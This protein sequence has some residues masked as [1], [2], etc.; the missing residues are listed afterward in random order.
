MSNDIQMG[1]INEAGAQSNLV[2][3]ANSDGVQ[4]LGAGS[5]SGVA[6]FGDPKESGPGIIGTGQGPGAPGVKGI[7]FEGIDS[8]SI[9]ACG[10]YGQ[11]GRRNSD[12]TANC[13]GVEGRGSGTYAG[14]A[15][16][17]D[18]SLSAAGGIG[19]YA[20]GG[21]PLATSGQSGGPGVYA[22]GFGGPLYTPLNETAGVYGVGGVSDGPGV[23]GQGTTVL[24]DGVRGSATG[25]S[26]VH[27]ISGSGSGVKAES[28]SGVGVQASSSSG[29]GVVATGGQF[30]LIAS[31]NLPGGLAARFDGKVLIN[32]SLTIVG[33]KK[34][35]AVPFPD[36]S[37]RLLYCV[38]S[39]ESWFEDFGFGQLVNGQAEVHLD[40]GFSSIIADGDYHV[41]I[42][43]YEDHNALY[44]TKRSSTG[45]T[46]RSKT[47]KANGAFS[48]RV[49]AKRKDVLAPRFEEVSL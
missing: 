37:H 26:G 2:G 7:G 24:A 5:F 9:T 34:S 42:T 49:T 28:N 32:G 48:Y 44:I 43:E 21:A 46:V 25:G 1:A 18:V 22:V 45:F 35:A 16:F 13:N 3:K 4:G 41:A 6:G 27:G 40:P 39:P 20:Q 33:G 30:G 8:S 23:L 36:G 12:G 10:V 31:A 29:T 38:E 11:A 15:G 19:I 47:A 17:G 14:V